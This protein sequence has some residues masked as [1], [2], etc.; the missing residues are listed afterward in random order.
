MKVG[1]FLVSLAGLTLAIDCSLYNSQKE[2]CLS[3][4][5]TYCNSSN[6]CTYPDNVVDQKICADNQEEW[7]GSAYPDCV[8]VE[9]SGSGFVAFSIIVSV[10]L[11]CLAILA[12][13]LFIASRNK[14]KR[15][16]QT[17][18]DIP[19]NNEPPAVRLDE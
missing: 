19:M 12:I 17:N 14:Q 16:E 3:Y 7:I 15:A 6:V 9:E 11:G 1:L 18:S 2:T 8:K 13:L 10:I 4:C 5:C